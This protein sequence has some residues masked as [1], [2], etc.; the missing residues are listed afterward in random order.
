MAFA[1]G[2][3][4]MNTHNKTLSVQR[5]SD[6]GYWK[7]LVIQLFNSSAAIFWSHQVEIQFFFSLMLIV[8]VTK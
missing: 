2:I 6:V 3:V 5:L 7:N 4:C 1:V 8:H